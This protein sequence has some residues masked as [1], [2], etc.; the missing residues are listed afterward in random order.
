M[1][2]D[3]NEWP[4]SAS[5]IAEICEVSPN[6]ARRWLENDSGPG[7]ARKLIQLTQRQRIMPDSW[8]QHWRINGAGALDVGFTKIALTPAQIEWYFFS[9]D[10]WHQL[11]ALLP[12]IESRMDELEKRATTATIIELDKYRAQLRK[13]RERPFLLS[14]HK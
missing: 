14:N 9:C 2:L 8:P 6:T 7:A 11:L 1:F 10:L 3:P 13:F 5:R 12:T 4:I